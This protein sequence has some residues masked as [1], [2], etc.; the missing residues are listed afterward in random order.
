MSVGT[1]SVTVVGCQGPYPGPSGATSGFL[2]E[3]A[4]FRL[5]LDCGSGVLAALQAFCRPEELDA[6]LLTHLHEDHMA[7][8]GVLGYA[9]QTE[10]AQG[11][12]TGALPLYATHRPED[13]YARL[14]WKGFLDVRPLDPDDPPEALEIG[15]LR[16]TFARTVHAWPCL[17]VRLEHAGRAFAYSAD[18]GWTDAVPRL[19]AGADVFL[20]EA[21]FL[22]PEVPGQGPG[23]LTGRQAGEMARAAG[24]RRLY[25]THV[26]PRFEP[27]RLVAQAREVFPAAEACWS[28]LR[29]EI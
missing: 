20:C 28:G 2:V 26:Y 9:L 8:V 23:H 29:I 6:V 24:A 13:A 11:R 25:L 27:A 12:F 15:P 1:F 19:A 14:G 10:A 16:A 18:T 3:A 4:G 21:S 22:E 17:A 5:L 7:D